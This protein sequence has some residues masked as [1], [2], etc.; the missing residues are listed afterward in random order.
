MKLIYIIIALSFAVPCSASIVVTQEQFDDIGIIH[1]VIK[2]KYPQFIGF[3]GSKDNLNGSGLSDETLDMEIRRM[4][5]Q[6]IK[7]GKEHLKKNKI[8]NTIKK[9]KD[10]GL[11]D[12]DIDVLG[13]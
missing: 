5:I 6:K 8:E 13:L 9:L 11:D 3:N 12:N 2:D 4:D 1:E 10:L 7:Q